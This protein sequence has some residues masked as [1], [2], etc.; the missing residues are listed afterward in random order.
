MNDFQELSHNLLFR[1][2]LGPLRCDLENQSQ[3]EK[4]DNL[5]HQLLTDIRKMTEKKT[6]VIE[7]NYLLNDD[8]KTKK[9]S[10]PHERPKFQ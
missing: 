1:V 5:Q 8:V 10:F 9:L 2:N 3:Q 4:N 6:I 7:L